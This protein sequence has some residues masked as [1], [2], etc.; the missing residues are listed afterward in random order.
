LFSVRIPLVPY[1][2]S[3]TNNID[4]QQA[5]IRAVVDVTSY[6]K[7]VLVHVTARDETRVGG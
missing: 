3:V 7:Q 2:R 6:P 5:E 1:I 4:E